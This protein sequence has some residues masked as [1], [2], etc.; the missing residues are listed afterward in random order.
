[1]R[2]II[3]HWTAGT[4]Q[5]CLDD[6]LHYHYVVDSEGKIHNGKFL[7]EDNENCYDGKYAAH[8]GGGNTASI[9]IAYCGCYVP[10]NTS[11]KMTKYPLT[12]KQL[13]AGFKLGA[14]LAKKYK[15]KLAD[16]ESVQTHYGFGKRNPKTS[17]AGK[18]DINFLHEYP[19]LQASE[20]EGFIRNKVLWYFNHL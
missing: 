20:I 9:G 1:M 17:S 10:A 19:E 6:F 4:N 3:Y 14:E 13:E 2:R 18:I 7:P 12:K 8:T 15:I 11:V 16:K 5:P